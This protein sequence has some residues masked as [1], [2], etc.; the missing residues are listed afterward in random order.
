MKAPRTFYYMT[1]S[2]VRSAVAIP[3]LLT[4]SGEPEDNFNETL[5]LP[6]GKSGKMIHTYIDDETE[7]VITDYLGNEGYFHE[8]SSIHL[9]ES[10]Y[11]FSLKNDYIKFLENIH[12]NNIID[13]GLT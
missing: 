6:A 13:N 3:Y 7:G 8:L 11:D 9:K 4:L 12:N 5:N 1:V 2:G 10:G